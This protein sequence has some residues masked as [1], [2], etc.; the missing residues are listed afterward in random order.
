MRGY[1]N[2]EDAT[3]LC[4]TENG[5]FKSGDSAVIKENGAVQITDRLKELIKVEFC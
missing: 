4:I 3:K 5:W 1:R 2:N